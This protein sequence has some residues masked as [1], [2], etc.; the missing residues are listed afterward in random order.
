MVS[1]VR[2]PVVAGAFYPA[3]ES[4]LRQQLSELFG[5]PV[6]RPERRL[7][8]PVGIVAPHAGYAYSGATAARAFAWLAARGVPDWAIVLGANHTGWGAPISVDT[9]AGWRTPLGVVRLADA[10]GRLARGA[11]AADGRAFLREHS[12]EVQLPLLQ[13]ALGQAVP[14]VP[15]CVASREM[16]ALRDAAAQIAEEVAGQAVALVASSDFTHYEPQQMAEEKDRRAMERILQLDVAGFLEM[17]RSERLSICGA[18]A[19]ALLMLLGRQCGWETG[20]CLDYTTSG[21]L[22]GER[23]A[24]VGYAAVGWEEAD[25]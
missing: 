3:D 14:F 20:T 22:T 7:P 15:V 6:K 9:S 24:V 25:G 21:D 19:I 11:L 12:V 1:H 10:A 2:E 5:G 13:Y 18:G 23:D 8:G 4:A 17:V 16:G